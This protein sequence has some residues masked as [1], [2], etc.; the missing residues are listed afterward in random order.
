M[1]VGVE[2]EEDLAGSVVNLGTFPSQVARQLRRRALAVVA[3]LL[4]DER[5][6]SSRI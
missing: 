6:S 1:G 4:P 3:I 5:R 2:E